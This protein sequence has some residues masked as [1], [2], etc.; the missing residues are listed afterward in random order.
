M[1]NGTQHQLSYGANSLSEHPAH[2][3]YS[4]VLMQT[5]IYLKTLWKLRKC[6]KGWMFTHF[7]STQGTNLIFLWLEIFTFPDNYSTQARQSLC[8]PSCYILL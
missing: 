6:D 7:L 3:Y 2:V 5:F 1:G 8:L 4:C